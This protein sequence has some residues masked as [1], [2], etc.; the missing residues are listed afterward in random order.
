MEEHDAEDKFFAG[1]TA[2]SVALVGI[3]IL[4]GVITAMAALWSAGLINFIVG[5][6]VIFA[7]IRATVFI[8]RRILE[9]DWL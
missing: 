3:A 6:V 8:Y 5:G 2:I 4:F 1:F 9:S 7:F